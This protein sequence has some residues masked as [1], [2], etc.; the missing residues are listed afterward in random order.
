[1][2]APQRGSDRPA[3]RRLLPPA[4]P[5]QRRAPAR[6][7]DPPPAPN[8]P[9]VS[10]PVA[11][12]AHLSATDRAGTG[13]RLDRESPAAMSGVRTAVATHDPSVPSSGPHAVE[14]AG[15][16][17]ELSARLLSADDLSQALNRL[18]A[19]TAAAIPAATRCAVV[20]IGENAPLTHAASGPAAQALDRLQ[21][22]EGH[23]PSLDA[24]RTR[25][26]VT[27]QNLP[28]DP[29][30]PTLADQAHADGIQAVAAVPLDVHRAAVGA[31]T[32]YATDP[33]GVDP[34]LLLTIMAIANQAEILLGEVHRRDGLT[35]G[36]TVDR[37]A[38]VIIAQRGC[39]IQEAYT[40]LQDTAHRLGLDRKA[41]AERLITAAARNAD[42]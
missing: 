40:V 26:L 19:V 11:A 34:D 38:G 16:L 33:A 5:H 20:L 9:A 35:E 31:L 30:W 4:A 2:S 41:V 24:A 14:L 8:P 1:V 7:T 3:I 17:H 23:G 22:A 37:A 29:R 21:Y 10:D 36:A 13:V 42:L 27:T 6:T 28:T 12:A 25:A 15:L 32:I 39:G 18:A